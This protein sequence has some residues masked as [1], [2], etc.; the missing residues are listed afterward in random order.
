MA[1]KLMRVL[2]GGKFLGPEWQGWMV[3]RDT[4]HTPEGHTLKSHEMAWWSLLIRQAREFQTIMRN[5]RLLAGEDSDRVAGAGDSPALSIEDLQ[6]QVRQ[7]LQE[8]A[9]KASEA[10]QA[11]ITAAFDSQPALR[12]YFA[13]QRRPAQ[14]GNTG[15]TD[16]PTVAKLIG[17]PSET[18]VFKGSQQSDSASGG[19][20]SGTPEGASR[21]LTLPVRPQ[22]AQPSAAPQAS[23]PEAQSEAKAV[24]A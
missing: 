7:R 18:P 4:L 21:C 10:S 15:T 16:Q 23:A 11:A 14:P 1:F 2:K 8:A 13:R 12:A 5:R 20:T 3:Q 17:C 6:A 24:R 9:Q 19:D 22:E